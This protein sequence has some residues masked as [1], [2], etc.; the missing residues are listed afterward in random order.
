MGGDNFILPTKTVVE[1]EFIND[2]QDQA[3][4]KPETSEE[5][6]TQKESD[7][8]A[9][10]TTKDKEI[11]KKILALNLKEKQEDYNS[12]YKVYHTRN[13][14]DDYY[15]AKKPN[16]FS[17]KLEDNLLKLKQM[18]YYH[19]ID[20]NGFYLY[21]YHKYWVFSNVRK[22]QKTDHVGRR[23]YDLQ[24][25]I[26]PAEEISVQQ[27]LSYFLSYDEVNLTNHNCQYYYSL[28]RKK[29]NNSLGTNLEF[30]K[31]NLFL[32]FYKMII[33]SRLESFGIGLKENNFADYQ[34]NYKFFRN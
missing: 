12:N 17:A 18:S 33:N 9:K 5:R 24:G 27:V 4:I 6:F 30:N 25:Y 13:K 7:Q 2:N 1:R 10:L 29:R 20:D 28:L 15:F 19:L 31:K 14:Q 3:I 11:V 21:N 16:F 8:Q 32:L 34:F 22:T 23:I 26:Y